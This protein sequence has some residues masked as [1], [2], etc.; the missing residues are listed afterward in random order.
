M[1]QDKTP[2][3]ISERMAAALAEEPRNW[4]LIS[5]MAEV[6]EKEGMSL[7]VRCTGTI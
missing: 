1:L 4:L 3:Q 5:S 7:P 2:K 6:L